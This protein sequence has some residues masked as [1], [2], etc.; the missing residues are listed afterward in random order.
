MF[1]FK[2]N[3]IFKQTKNTSRISDPTRLAGGP[4]PCTSLACQLPGDISR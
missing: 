4:I 1:Y 2:N 3:I